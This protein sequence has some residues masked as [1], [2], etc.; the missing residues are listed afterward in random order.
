MKRFCESLREHEMKII[1]FEKRQL[2]PLTKEQQE[3]HEKTT[4]CYICK[5]IQT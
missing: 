4:V 3:S 2:I 5:N 1:Y